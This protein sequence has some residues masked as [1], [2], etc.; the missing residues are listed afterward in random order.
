MKLIK[1]SA[2]IFTALI[3]L[4]STVTF[5][6]NAAKAKAKKVTVSRYSEKQINVKKTKAQSKYTFICSVKNNG[7]NCIRAAVLDGEDGFSLSIFGRK[8]TKKSPVVTVYYNKD[9]ARV[10]VKKYSVTVKDAQKVSF[11]D[12]NINTGTKKTVKLNNPYYK[13]YSFKISDK[14]IAKIE[15]GYFSDGTD[16]SYKMKG[17]K[18]GS[19]EVNV[20]LEGTGFKAGSFKINV[21][22]FPAAVKKRYKALELK[23]N[24]HGSNAYMSKSHVILKNIITDKKAKAKYSVVSDNENV[25]SSLDTGEV[26]A[27]GKGRA[28]CTV[29]EKIGKSAKKSIDKFS[30][31][32][33]KA[34]MS[35]VA[36][37]NSMWYNDGIFGGGEFVEYLNLTDC[38][39]LKTEETIVRC[40][41][42]N[43]QTGSHFKQSQYKITYKSTNPGVASVSSNGVVTAK[44]PGSA[45]IIYKISF[46]D[47]SA[48]TD[49]CPVEVETE[50]TD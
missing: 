5:G 1:R 41:I 39:T 25:V 20:Y 4:T 10:T 46:S 31:K 19:T 22:D 26:Y 11:K 42:N 23:Y 43:R 28:T 49:K 32:V 27:T 16:F 30:V 34:K 24:S 6:A 9:G 8:P 48:Y 15:M 17:L 47:G 36:E 38:K 18:K 21:G 13:D 40:L 37:E 14:K 29:Y 2:A 35:Y 45:T 50:E 33:T 12:V 7:K 3:C 44:K